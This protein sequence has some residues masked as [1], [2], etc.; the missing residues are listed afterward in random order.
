MNDQS[1][2][3]V[4][5]TPDCCIPDIEYKRQQLKVPMGINEKCICESC[6]K[7]WCWIF[8]VLVEQ[9]DEPES[10]ESGEEEGEEEGTESDLVR[11][12]IVS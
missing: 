4:C 12:A 3:N 2:R 9:G 10:E 5:E 7:V 8:L 1:Q 6:L 11:P